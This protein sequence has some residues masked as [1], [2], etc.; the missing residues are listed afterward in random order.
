MFILH[1]HAIEQLNTDYYL[2][3]E[4]ETITTT[5]IRDNLYPK[6]EAVLKTPE[7][8]KKFSRL[9]GDFV[10]RN[11]SK[12]T[13]IGP[14]Y[15]VPFTNTDKAMYYELFNTNEDEIK[16]MVKEI[17]TKVN[18]KSKWSL[19]QNNPIYTL[20][21]CVIRYFT[22]LK[23]EKQLNNALIITALSFYPSSYSKYFKYDPNPGVMHYTIDNLSQRFIIKK[24]NHVFGMLAYSIQG[25]WKFHEKDFHKGTDW[26]VI[27]FIQRIRNDQNSLMKKIMNN[28]M[29]NHKKGLTVYT[30]VDQ[31]DDNIVVDN[32]NDTNKVEAIT[33][34]IVTA[35]LV[36]G[37]DLSLCD[38]AASAANVSKID[39]RNYLTKI[40]IEKNTKV[41][42]NFVESILFLYLYDGKHTF[43]DINSKQ[44]IAFSLQTF[45]RTNSKDPNITNIKTTLDKWGDESGIYGKFSRLATRVDYT[46]AIFLY[47]VTSIQKYA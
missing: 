39:L 43:A 41:M 17:T 4:A 8:S 19:I 42:Y 2:L 16:A 35:L 37:V 20:F 38:F 40:Q 10:N 45:K 24:S 11:S 27:R 44:F 9:V 47:F 13:T 14:Q 46:K 31:Y 1:E 3:I 25:S 28:Y 6:V 7:G 34:K 23:D 30:Q 22:I 12:L 18:D 36:N 21:Y 33:N 29:I 26:E 15:L 5:I 32:E